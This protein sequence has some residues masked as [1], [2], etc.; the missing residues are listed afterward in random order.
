MSHIQQ[1]EAFFFFYCY[2]L[3]WSS[4]LRLS[5]HFQRQKK[6]ITIEKQQQNTGEG[7]IYCYMVL[8]MRKSLKE[9][10]H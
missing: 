6:L 5:L 4:L 3:V 10:Q 7:I 8:R 2:I 1:N 9:G